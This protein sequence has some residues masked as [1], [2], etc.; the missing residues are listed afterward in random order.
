MLQNTI[1][2]AHR[3]VGAIAPFMLWYWLTERN[4]RRRQEVYIGAA[5]RV[6]YCEGG[7][8]HG[9]LER[10]DSTVHQAGPPNNGDAHAQSV[11]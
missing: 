7:R 8:T 2:Q 11:F 10:V 3:K 5:L 1:A 6:H 4:D 9:P